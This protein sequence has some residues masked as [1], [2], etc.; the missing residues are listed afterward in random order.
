MK[1][2]VNKEEMLS[3]AMLNIGL[4]LGV[5]RH[6]SS[7]ITFR[8]ELDVMEYK[9]Y[10]GMEY[11]CKNWLESKSNLLSL[12]MRHKDYD[13]NTFS[14]K[15]EIYTE[16]SFDHEEW[17]YLVNALFSEA[18]R[19]KGFEYLCG[20]NNYYTCMK[21]FEDSKDIRSINFFENLHKDIYHAGMKKSRLLMAYLKKIGFTDLPSFNNIFAKMADLL[22]VKKE[23]RYIYLSL[24]PADI[25]T[26]SNPHY[27]EKSFLTS[28]HSLDSEYMYRCGNSGY[29]QD[30]VTFI[31]F[32][33][34]EDNKDARYSRKTDRQLFMYNGKSLIQSRLYYTGTEKQELFRN[35][36]LE[37]MQEINGTPASDWKVKR[38]T[39]D[40]IEELMEDNPKYGGY[41]DFLTPEFNI[42][43]IY[44]EGDEGDKFNIG[45][46]TTCLGCGRVIGSGL[47]CN[48][49]KDQFIGIF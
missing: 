20:I 19:E 9:D 2:T 15:K 33:T 29:C 40:E 13:K 30:E 25:L 34:K 11:L 45:G 22:K 39:W 16:A 14:I 48:T 1:V 44:L 8:N 24:N 41:P 42:N 31:V 3:R 18:E 21:Y 12:F 47:V 27:M 7:S 43:H 46:E 35:F 4:A 5:Y 32:T 37:I 17:L 28:C 36:V 38:I 26:S 23:K 6:A 10:A 49:C